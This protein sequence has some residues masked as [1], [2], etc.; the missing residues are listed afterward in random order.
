MTADPSTDPSCFVRALPDRC[1][2][3]RA[4]PDLIGRLRD[5][6][7][8]RIVLTR[9]GDVAVTPDGG[10]RSVSTAEVPDGARWA[11]LGRDD[12]GRGILCAALTEPIS[13]DAAAWA[14]LRAL[15]ARLNEAD[16]AVAVTAVSVGR[17]LVE[18]A[19][20]PRCG[21]SCV[22][23]QSG[24]A[25]ECT[26]CG[27]DHFP[28]TDPAVIV[29]V[30]SEDG[31]RLLLGSNAGWGPDRF[32]CFAGF[33]EAGESLEDTV[34][35]EIREEAGV[36]VEDVHYRGSQAWPFPRSLMVGFHA[37]ARS[38]EEARADG[39]EI[40]KVRWFSRDEVRRALAGEGDAVMP[41]AASIA[42]SLIR[43]WCDGS[44]A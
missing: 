10:V 34:V 39:V 9:G 27:Q 31:Q 21:G 8:T 40:V 23:T 43:S 29:A 24:W 16:V 7:R 25:R 22:L 4:R 11:F 18:A 12:E 17:W 33:V 38:D 28:R 1:D 41:G 3:E 32:S 20:C 36:R 35:R 6:P 13:P 30:T 37:R 2:A 19:Y 5:D 44:A 14:S 26:E 15:G 42:R